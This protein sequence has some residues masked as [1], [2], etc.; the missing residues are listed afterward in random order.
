MRTG[1]GPGRAAGRHGAG[2]LAGLG[3]GGVGGAAGTALRL[4]HGLLL[5]LLV[6]LHHRRVHHLKGRLWEAGK[7]VGE[8]GG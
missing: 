6:L 2:R 8:P 5:V 1:E 7:E 4:D 3:A